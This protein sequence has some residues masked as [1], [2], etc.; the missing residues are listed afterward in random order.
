MGVELYAI[1][2]MLQSLPEII[3]KEKTTHSPSK[4]LAL[5]YVLEQKNQR[6]R[7]RRRW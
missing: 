5:N 7:T 3:V 2:Y 1:W 6:A 4:K